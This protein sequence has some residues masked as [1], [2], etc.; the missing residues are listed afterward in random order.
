LE[1]SIIFRRGREAPSRP[2]ILIVSRKEEDEAKRASEKYRFDK[3]VAALG[4]GGLY[5]KHVTPST[6]GSFERD[7]AG[8]AADMTFCSFF[9]FPG[10]A[11][12]EGYL[13]DA[14]INEGVAWIGSPPGTME[15]ALSKPRMKAHWRLCGIPTPAWFIVRKFQDGSIEGLEQM[16]NAQGFPFIVKPAN[17]GNSRGIDGGSVVRSPIELYARASSIVEEY[18]EALVERFVSGGED[19]REFTVAMIGNGSNA[20]VSPVEIKKATSDSTVIS[21]SDKELQATRVLPIEDGRLRDKVKNLARRIFLSSGARD[22]SRC[23]I[24]LHE[25]KLYAIEINGQPMV[26]DRWF[27]ACSR[28]AGLDEVQYINAIVLAGIIGN[29]RTGHAYISIPREMAQ[30]L[31]SPILERLTV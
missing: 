6:L 4:A 25:G 12:G 14:A 15:L 22:Y 1:V 3:M 2:R 16:E 21:E 19:S 23:D 5:A 8:F 13:Y 7:M 10:H 17:E 30:L 20:V 26:P 24:L 31:P 28:E 18:G 27:E 9:R 29:A 11:D